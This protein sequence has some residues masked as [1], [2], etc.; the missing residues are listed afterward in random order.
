MFILLFQHFTSR[1][2]IVAPGQRAE[3]GGAFC[4]RSMKT[5][6]KTLIN[7][8][9]VLHRRHCSLEVVH[10]RFLVHTLTEN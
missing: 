10:I 9:W 3:W 5:R 7:K 8:L 4:Q 1:V 6:G 2:Y